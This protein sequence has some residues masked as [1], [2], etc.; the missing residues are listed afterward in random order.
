MGE[1]RSWE[2][3]QLR[4]TW[5]TK[6]FLNLSLG[7]FQ[8]AA[9]RRP[10]PSAPIEWFVDCRERAFGAFGRARTSGFA[11]VGGQL[12]GDQHVP[13]RCNAKAQ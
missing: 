3:G 10:A 8:D 13:R 12:A 2:W 9:K 6:S 11:A 7:Q 5:K 4:A 1:K